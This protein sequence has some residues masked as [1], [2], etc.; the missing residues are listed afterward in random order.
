MM[1]L[2]YIPKMPEKTCGIFEIKKSFIEKLLPVDVTL[3]LKP[4]KSIISVRL[5]HVES[6]S[7]KLMKDNY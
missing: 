5:L 1:F 3:V 2:R 6:K 4:L 7:L